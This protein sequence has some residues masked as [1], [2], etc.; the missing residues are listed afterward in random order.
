MVKK[1]LTTFVF[2]PFGSRFRQLVLKPSY[3]ADK[4]GRVVLPEKSHSRLV[5]DG[6][7]FREINKLKTIPKPD[8]IISDVMMPKMNGYEFLEQ[9][10][11]QPQ[12][13]TAHSGTG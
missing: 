10:R 11:A 1:Y 3:M 9:V 12:W 6:Y 5:I 8:L 7:Y 4:W 13:Q 2:E